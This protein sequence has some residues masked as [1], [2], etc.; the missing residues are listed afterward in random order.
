MRQTKMH[1]QECYILSV[2]I[3]SLPLASLI[4][5]KS[6]WRL[7]VASSVKTARWLLLL[8]QTIQ[9]VTSIDASLSGIPVTAFSMATK[10]ALALK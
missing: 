10:N 9:G 8:L 1:Q 4:P 3:L 5:R 6:S 7:Q 2:D